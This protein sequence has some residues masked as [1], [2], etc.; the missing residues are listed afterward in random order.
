MKAAD[1]TIIIIV[2]WINLQLKTIEVPSKGNL[3]IDHKPQGYEIV[4]HCLYRELKQDDDAQD[5]DAQ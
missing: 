1:N 3:A 2:K 5:D 4:D